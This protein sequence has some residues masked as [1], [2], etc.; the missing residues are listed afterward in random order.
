[1]N[2]RGFL[3]FLP[4]AVIGGKQAAAEAAEK[5]A[6][7]NAPIGGLGL[8]DAD[9]S[10]GGGSYAANCIGVSASSSEW[11][12]KD[13]RRLI[14]PAWLAERRDEIRVQAL[15]PDLATMKSMSLGVRMQMQKDRLLARHVERERTRLEKIIAG[16]FD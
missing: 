13:L 15:D 1:M 7:G 3:K 14:D 11:A 5:L 6:L 9:S 16:I 8:M 4:A 10:L 12:I 2:R